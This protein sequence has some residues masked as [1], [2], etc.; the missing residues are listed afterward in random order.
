MV[1]LHGGVPLLGGMSVYHGWV[2]WWG[3]MARYHCWVLSG[4]RVELVVYMVV[5]L[6]ALKFGRQ[7]H[8]VIE[9]VLK[10]HSSNPVHAIRGLAYFLLRLLISCVS[11]LVF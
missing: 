1:G 10:W 9:K 6:A 4:C 7:V 11:S 2:A 8:S 5:F 3:V